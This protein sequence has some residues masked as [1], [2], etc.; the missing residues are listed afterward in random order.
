MV[1]AA[2]RLVH[3]DD[4]PLVNHA[5][6]YERNDGTLLLVVFDRR[7]WKTPS[8]YRRRLLCRVRMRL[9]QLGLEE[10]AA[11]EWPREG[12]G[13]RGSSVVLFLSPYSD[14][15]ARQAVRVFEEEVQRMD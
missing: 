9:D 4:W 2:A 13:R 3:E 6:P 7:P 15:L 11:A 12:G 10:I 14:D 1:E 5:W 8:R